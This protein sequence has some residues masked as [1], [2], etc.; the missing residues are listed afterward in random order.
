MSGAHAA[1]TRL[2]GLAA[3]LHWSSVGRSI[4]RTAGCNVALAAAGLG[5]TIP[6]R[7]FGPTARGDCALSS[8]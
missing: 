2:E 1:P 4:A 3:A 8:R 7:A 6:A 5:G